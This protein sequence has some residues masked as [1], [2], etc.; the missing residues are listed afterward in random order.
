MPV[1]VLQMQFRQNYSASRAA[2]VLLWQVVELWRREMIADY[3]EPILEE[4]LAGEIAAGRISAP[5]W[6]DPRMR[7]AWLAGQ[8]IGFPMPNIDPLK[9]AKAEREYASLGA[10][11][12]DRIAHEYNG[13]SGKSNRAKLAREIEELPNMGGSAGEMSGNTDEDEDEE[14]END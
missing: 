9:A 3:L 12:L 14:I 13:S 2:L 8:W 4:W 7:R 5:G 1:E 6:S 10:T 11:T